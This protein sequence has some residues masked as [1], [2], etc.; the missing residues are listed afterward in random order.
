MSEGELPIKIDGLNIDKVYENFVRQIAG[1]D[2]Q[3]ETTDETLAESVDRD[4]R[5]KELT[6]QIENLQAKMRKEKQLNKQ[7][8]MNAEIK[9]LKKALEEL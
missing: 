6:K 4:E 8:E 3:T 7:V 2:L 1:N 5:R 9:K